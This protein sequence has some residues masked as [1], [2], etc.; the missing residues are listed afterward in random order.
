MRHQCQPGVEP[1][2]VTTIGDATVFFFGPLGEHVSSHV[3]T[4]P[5]RVS[6]HS[7]RCTFQASDQCLPPESSV[8]GQARHPDTKRR[9]APRTSRHVFY[10]TVCLVFPS[11]EACVVPR[12]RSQHAERIFLSALVPRLN[13][14]LFTGQ[15]CVGLVVVSGSRR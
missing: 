8:N 13:V 12:P 15:G 9:A 11:V 10:V 7:S 5:C 6:A 14:V 2:F 1:N 3:T 4:V